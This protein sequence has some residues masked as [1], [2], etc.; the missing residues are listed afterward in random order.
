MSVVLIRS[1]IHLIFGLGTTAAHTWVFIWW[2]SY[3][4]P[5]YWGWGC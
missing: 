1:L 2:T 4:C 3:H 5:D